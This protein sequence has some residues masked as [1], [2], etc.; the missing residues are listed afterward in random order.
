ME[1]VI[2]SHLT[3]ALTVERTTLESR[4]RGVTRM[5]KSDKDAKATAGDR[6]ASSEMWTWTTNVY[7]MR[8]REE[9]SKIQGSNHPEYGLRN[10]SV[11]LLDSNFWFVLRDKLSSLKVRCLTPAQCDTT[12]KRHQ[13]HSQIVNNLPLWNLSISITGLNSARE[14]KSLK[15]MQL[16][17]SRTLAWSSPWCVCVWHFKIGHRSTLQQGFYKYGKDLWFCG[18]VR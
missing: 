15:D 4:K 12:L 3:R 18:A 6:S 11:K 10:I 7:R 16:T 17:C 5:W 2:I 13:A 14:N 8:Q 9:D 1:S